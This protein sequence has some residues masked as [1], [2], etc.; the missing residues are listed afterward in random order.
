M[1]EVRIVV[2]KWNVY[3]GQISARPLLQTCKLETTSL[4]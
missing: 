3:E 1:L 4:C 2:E